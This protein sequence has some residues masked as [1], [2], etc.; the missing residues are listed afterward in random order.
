MFA[1]P[2]SV[3]RIMRSDMEKIRFVIGVHFKNRHAYGNQVARHWIDALKE[4]DFSSG[5]SVALKQIKD[6]HGL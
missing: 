1:Y 4:K 2:G 6:E 3:V 5:Y